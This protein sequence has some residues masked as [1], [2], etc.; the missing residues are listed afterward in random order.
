[1][2]TDRVQQ[3][4]IK[5]VVKKEA[6]LIQE[7][8]DGIS[9]ELQRRN[10]SHR[11]I[12]TVRI[13]IE[14]ITDRLDAE[15]RKYDVELICCGKRTRIVI[16]YFGAAID[17]LSPSSARDDDLV[18]TQL[19]SS[20]LKHYEH[21]WS[22]SSR[23]GKNRI[24]IRF[25]FREHKT[26]NEAVSNYYYKQKG[27]P[28]RAF[29]QLVALIRAHPGR[30]LV[31]LM[32]K[33]F[34]HL[35]ML[36]IPVI[37]AEIINMAAYPEN[38]QTVKLWNCFAVAS[39]C[40]GIN[41]L[42]AWLDSVVF[43]GFIR[44]LEFAIRDAMADK[45]HLLSLTFHRKEHSGKLSS[46]ILR[47]VETLGNSLR[48]AVSGY[49]NALSDI[50][51][52]LCVTAVLCPEMLLF[53]IPAIPAA[54]LMIISFRKPMKRRNKELHGEME[55][56]Y[57]QTG[58]M[59]EMMP[60]ARDM[61]LRERE[62]RKMTG[63]FRSVYRS[64]IALD[65]LNHLFSSISSAVITLL[66]LVCLD[67]SALLAVHGKIEAGT[68]LL[69][70]TYF[71][72]II[73]STTKVLERV[74]D[75]AAGIRSAESIAELMC[76]SEEEEN[77]SIHLSSDGRLEIRLQDVSFTYEDTG[78]H[79][80]NELNLCVPAGTRLAITGGS[81]SGKSTLLNLITGVIV[82]QTG[83][84][85]V[86]GVPMQELEK[87]H[88]RRRIAVVP[89]NTVLFAGTL[90]ENLT[91]GAPYASREEVLRVIQAVNLEEVIGILP[92]GLNT[93]MTEHGSLLSGGQRQR[94][95]IARALLR[96]PELLIM[97]E[98]TSA[99]DAEAE[100]NVRAAV[101]ALPHHCTVILVAHRLSA[102]RG[103]KT[104]AVLKNGRITEMGTY[105]QMIQKKGEFCRIFRLYG[106]EDGNG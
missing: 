81:G 104:I 68:V 36:V 9:E 23:R 49:L 18:L 87:D 82:P 1:M 40:L 27:T 80:L 14:E 67:I 47:D 21:W 37:T 11:D 58:E 85:T 26:L 16:S 7:K 89:Q 10:L 29:S 19:R 17:L 42:F 25:A 53:F 44:K 64:G 48:F 63:Y 106:G 3:P 92:N 88:Y 73:E 95:A 20:I 38:F 15:H 35:P 77:G 46:R 65:R 101:D 98:A 2:D 66:K 43:V 71:S 6:M 102:V 105:E 96:E 86:N 12:Q 8:M 30:I 33:L 45:L 70:E 99:L 103:M 39:I 97:D 5:E 31:C 78:I 56:S 76:A 91:Y 55:R 61:G 13:L 94:I 57:M 93:V 84:I 41:V 51:T 79:A 72:M 34:R 24:F 22:S 100:R 62:K 59:L 75:V 4:L 83:S 60:L 90:W 28:P 74:P 54:A 32:I 50:I 52:A 69:F